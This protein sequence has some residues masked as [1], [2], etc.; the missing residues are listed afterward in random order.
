MNDVNNKATAIILMHCPDKKGIVAKV[1]E[2]ISE[3]NGNILYLEQHVD[4]EDKEFFMRLELD[5]ENFAIPEE[6]IADYFDTLIAQKYN[7][8]WNIYFSSQVPRMAIFVSKMSHCLF[9]L[10][11]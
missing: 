10:L 1:T 4:H 9:D 6:K 3:N 2:F 11:S 5:L 8:T 7:M